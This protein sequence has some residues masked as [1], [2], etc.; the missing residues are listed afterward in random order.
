MH[1]AVFF[2]GLLTRVLSN[3]TSC[4]TEITDQQHRLIL[5]GKASFVD[6]HGRECPC[7]V[8]P[9]AQGLVVVAEDLD[10]APVKV[11]IGAIVTLA[12]NV[13]EASVFVKDNVHRPLFT[14]HLYAAAQYTIQRLVGT[15]RVV[16]HV[17]GHGAHY[18]LPGIGETVQE[19]EDELER[20][21][22]TIRELQTRLGDR[23]DTDRQSGYVVNGYLNTLRAN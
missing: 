22:L 2:D 13:I 3:G 21:R 4:F 20:N 11:V 18:R 23:V 19:V 5:A 14:V 16:A 9:V 17:L 10:H 1:S 15:T 12:D 6:A 8:L 7:A